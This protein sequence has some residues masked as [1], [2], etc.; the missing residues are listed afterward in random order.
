MVVLVKLLRSQ[1]VCKLMSKDVLLELVQLD[2]CN[3]VDYF[4]R[5]FEGKTDNKFFL[6]GD[7]E[8]NGIS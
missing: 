7:Y 1:S 6:V 3:A 5:S 4:C 8:Q 2:E